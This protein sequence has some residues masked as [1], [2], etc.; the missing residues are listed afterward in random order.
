V[1]S[2]LQ[3]LARPEASGVP[4]GALSDSRSGQRGARGVVEPTYRSAK[5]INSQPLR[6]DTYQ[7]IESD[8]SRTLNW[9]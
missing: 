1:A 2:R 3:G 7:C 4:A 8:A 6:T 5:S 9:Q